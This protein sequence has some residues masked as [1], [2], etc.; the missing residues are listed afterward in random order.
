LLPAELP[1]FDAL[2]FDPEGLPA[3][4][5][6]GADFL[7]ESTGDYARF[8]FC[9]ALEGTGGHAWQVDRATFDERLA[10][11]ARALGAEVRF[12]VRATAV[13]TP[14]DRAGD[15]AEVELEGGEVLQARYVVDATGRDRLLCKQNRS[16]ERI[17]G[18]GVAAVWAH[19]DALSDAAVERLTES[20][21]ITVL[22]LDKGWGWVI[23]LPKG[24]LSVGFV[25]SERGVVS[26]AWF[27]EQYAKSA[28]LQE[29][30]AG[31]RR[32]ELSVIGDYSF[33]N[34][35]PFGPRYGCVG[36]ASAFLDP[37]F[38]SG[39][40]FAMDSAH[41]LVELLEPA[42]R[43]G[44]EAAPDLLEPLAAKMNRAYEVFGALI[45][46]FY[47]T[48][49]VKNLFFYDDPDPQLRAGL[50]SILA[51]DVWRDDNPFQDMVMRSARRRARRGANPSAA[52]S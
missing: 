3:V 39:V 20:G 2:G 41:A 23:P 51:G 49:L 24:R 30:T 22:I 35:Q 36:D 8:D 5:K 17:D 14:E 4:Y 40:A 12:G 26:E 45:H 16:F 38:S 13:R 7:D 10:A 21:N 33:K 46:S 9:D 28:F 47:H 29:L 15:R 1:V 18:F 44:R 37:V 19:F 34:T 25:S 50:I 27:E 11:R 52:A 6:A 32:S 42:L 43:E 48:N 31:A